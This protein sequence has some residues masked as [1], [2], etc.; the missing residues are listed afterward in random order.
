MD[1]I[2]CKTV[3]NKAKLDCKEVIIDE[4]EFSERIYL[5][6]DGEEYDIRTWNF[7]TIKTDNN[8]NPCAEIVDYALYK[9]IM[10]DEH[11]GHGEEICNGQTQITWINE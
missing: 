4:I 1:R 10:D 8:G 9:M 3:I 7:R 11:F 6:I 5:I 2:F